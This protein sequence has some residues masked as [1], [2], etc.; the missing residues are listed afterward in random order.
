MENKIQSANDAVA[1]IEDG[2]VIAINGFIMAGCADELLKALSDRFEREGRPRDLTLVLIT[3]AGDG[4]GRGADRLAHPG[5][6]KRIISSHYSFLPQIQKLIFDNEIE[7]YDF[8]Q[9]IMS[10]LLRDKAS[11]QPFTISPL[12]LDTFVDPRLEG[13]RLN[14]RTTEELTEIVRID[15]QEYIRYASLP[16][17]DYAFVRGSYSDSAGNVS[18]REEGAM[19]DA[20]LMAQ[21]TKNSGGKVLCQVGGMKQNL[22]A[23]DVRLPA[24]LTDR[25]IPV[26]DMH[27]HM[28]SAD[29]IYNPAY[30]GEDPLPKPSYAPVT[31]PERRIIAGRCLQE[32][33]RDAVINLGIGMPECIAALAAEKGID[34]FT[35]TVDVGI[36]G[37][38][39]AGGRDFGCT[40]NPQAIL[41]HSEIL[42]FFHGGGLD[43][44]F[45]GLAE[46]DPCGN[47]NV[48]RFK[49]R[50]TGIGG[51]VDLTQ[52]AHKVYLIGTFTA[53]GL[54]VAAADG[55]LSILREGK[56]RKFRQTIE[57]RTF[58]A[59]RSRQLGQ[60]VMFITERAV[61]R[62]TENG[63]TLVEIA[64][65]IDLQA[66]ILNHMDFLPHI[67]SDLKTMDAALF[68]ESPCC[69]FE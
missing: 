44:A 16:P 27:Y 67:S 6:I 58:S 40:I 28:Q 1:D 26:S 19:V 5:M 11:G 43:Q 55:Q 36:I 57:Q 53:K 33:E 60:E 20:F 69:S 64:P 66:D 35:L 14:Q 48:S 68:Q 12:G 3:S 62:L 51:F 56:I 2:A 49:G 46:C 32:L 42:D 54:E 45:L 50:I 41:F 47:V 10:Q 21:A 23:H 61:F 24:I 22:L 30:S 13:G 31:N 15:D 52:S 29:T 39:P 38:T 7:A 17:I 65:G 4:A 37:G 18:M 9:G 34:D 59:A 25:I 63:L 8:P